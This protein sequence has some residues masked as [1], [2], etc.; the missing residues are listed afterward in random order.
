MS[1]R[2]ILVTGATGY[3]AQQVIPSLAARYE[4]ILTDVDSRLSSGTLPTT[5]GAWDAAGQELDGIH[6]LDLLADDG[7]GLRELMEG[8][9]TVVHLAFKPPVGHDGTGGDL[10]GAAQS[11]YDGERDNIDMAQR[12]YQAALELGV[13]RVVVGSSN[14][15]AKWYEVPYFQGLKQAVSPEDVAKP[16]NFY[17][18][19]KASY[20]TLGFLYACGTLGRQLE[21]VQ[22]R[23]VAPRPIELKGFVGETAQRYFRDIAG[24]LSP[25]DLIQLVERAIDTPDIT[26]EHG[27]PWLVVY[28]VSNNDRKFWSLESAR[29]VLGYAPQD[30]SEVVFAAEIRK[31]LDSGADVITEELLGRP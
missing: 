6:E 23:I 28:G 3:V 10:L 8:V 22:L 1:T 25:R 12:I 2:R 24:Y 11:L 19:A 29:R 30:N 18:W 26:D 27:V 16:D 31:V 17:G 13:R 9:D 5:Q 14:Q 4:T 20:E 15:A 21:V 7:S